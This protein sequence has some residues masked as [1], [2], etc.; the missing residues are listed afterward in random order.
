MFP[1]PDFSGPLPSDFQ[2]DYERLARGFI[3]EG[4]L[5]LF[6]ELLSGIQKLDAVD[7]SIRGH[8]DVDFRADLAR[9]DTLAFPPEPDVGNVI[10]GIISDIHR[11]SPKNI[12]LQQ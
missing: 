1:K 4:N 2:R 12:L 10:S 11:S 3:R 8:I 9:L 7:F 6:N 5:L